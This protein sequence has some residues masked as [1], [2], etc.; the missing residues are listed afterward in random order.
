[1]FGLSKYSKPSLKLLTKAMPIDT[2]VTDEHKKRAETL[3]TALNTYGFPG[4]I[5][6]IRPGPMVTTYEFRP[7]MGVRI[8]DVVAAGTDIVRAVAARHIHITHIPGTDLL[9]IE[10]DNN[11]Q[12]IIRA[13]NLI[14]DKE[15]EKSNHRMP[16]ALGVLADGR[17]AYFDLNKLPHLL[18]AGRT[19]TGKSVFMQSI[20]MSLVYRFT[21]EECRLIIVDSKGVDFGFWHDIP[22]LITN[23][24]DNADGGIYA[25]KWAM[26]EMHRRE[27]LFKEHGVRN[28]ESY[29]ETAAQP[30][31]KIVVIVDELADLMALAKYDTEFTVNHLAQQA[32]PMGIHLIIATQ[33]PDD[34]VITD[35]I[36]ANFASRISFRARDTEESEMMLGESGAEHLLP[37]GDMLFS[38]GGRVPVR[39]HPAFIADDEI[40]AVADHLRKQG[41]PKYV[42]G[43]TECALKEQSPEELYA[44]AVDCVTTANKPTISYLQRQL[45]IGY[46]KAAELMERME[47]DGIVSAPDENGK[48]HL[49]EK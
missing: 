9:A 5:V 16:L 40:M 7:E 46:N 14:G 4:Q 47:A 19:G 1:M 32:R 3:Q 20:I 36:S 37:C 44:Q 30:L 22:H 43:V 21:P 48:R 26:R 39:I 12:Q 42:P 10:L 18:I 13:G 17:P 28:I 11:S 33:R 23:V 34:M 31:P 8:S 38:E 25:L 6:D 2:T 41:T 45:M 49:I 29:N 27:D 15:F 24:I 35:A